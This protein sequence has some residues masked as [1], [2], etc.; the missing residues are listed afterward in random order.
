MPQHQY[1]SNPTPSSTRP[2]SS[3]N[4]PKPQPIV[5]N[6][7]IAIF[8]P[9]VPHICQH[10]HRIRQRPRIFFSQICSYHVETIRYTA[11]DFASA[12]H[13]SFPSIF[14]TSPEQK[15][16]TGQK[17]SSHTTTPN[18]PLP[19]PI[20]HPPSLHPPDSRPAPPQLPHQPPR[21]RR[22][23]PFQHPTAR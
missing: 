21:P 9:P 4:R 2:P 17:K 7:A 13:P 22:A 14:Q 18:L 1:L 10:T 3:H 19:I 16:K 23:L 15:S 20:F 5:L 8:L 12:S 11:C 6:L